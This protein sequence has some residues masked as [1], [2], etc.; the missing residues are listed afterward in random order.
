MHTV[1]VQLC[2]R[3]RDVH[4]L[5]DAELR[6]RLRKPDRAHAGRVDRNHLSGLDVTHVVRADDVEGARLARDHPSALPLAEDER[7]KPVAV[8]YAEQMRLVHQHE[9]ERAVE[10]RQHAFERVLEV[11]TVRAQLVGV[12]PSDELADEF[13]VGGEDAG[14]HAQAARK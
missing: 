13:A 10:S 4:E 6:L 14:Q 1:A 5:E 12:L 8:S 7:A 11:A 2:V 3:P 9:R